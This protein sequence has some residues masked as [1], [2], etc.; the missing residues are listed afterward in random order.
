MSA[1]ALVPSIGEDF[2]DWVNPF[3]VKELRQGLHS[4]IFVGVFVAL[5]AAVAMAMIMGFLLV[6][7][8]GAPFQ[9]AQA[10]Q[11]AVESSCLCVLLPMGGYAAVRGE[12]QAD[13]LELI[14]VAGVSS[15][16]IVFGKWQA[17]L[18]LATMLLISVS[19]YHLLQYYLNHAG[20]L[21]Q[22]AA[23]FSCWLVSLLITSM[24]M[25]YATLN[26]AGRVG[27]LVL[28]IP[29]MLFVLGV[30]LAPAT[31]AV[32]AAGAGVIVGL[33]ME[34]VITAGGLLFFLSLTV[35]GIDMRVRA[36][37]QFALIP[38]PEPGSKDY[39]I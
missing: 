28:G 13:S 9:L 10:M 22:V 39:W 30:V 33:I 19:P 5:H 35:S 14:R 6:Q 11:W 17:Q 3:V 37:P 4:R 20:P 36:I 7:S 2:P 31:M 25:F 8:Q 24:M 38:P 26:A 29:V 23:L 34:I 16:Q 15:G 12:L 1:S 21:G 32:T 18:C 27:C